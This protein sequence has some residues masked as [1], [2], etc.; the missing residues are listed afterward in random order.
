M[1]PEKP[2]ETDRKIEYVPPSTD[3]VRRYSHAV[4]RQLYNDAVAKANFTELC[5][6]LTEFI[7]VVVRIETHAHNRSKNRV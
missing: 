3:M 1:N 5:Q 2:V 7:S 6:G 4:S